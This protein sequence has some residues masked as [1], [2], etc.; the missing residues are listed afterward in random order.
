[1]ELVSPGDS[2]A[3]SA[4]TTTLA[5]AHELVGVDDLTVVTNSLPVAELLQAAG[6]Q[7]LTVVLTGGVRTP[8]DALVGPVAVAALRTLH[9]DWLFLGVHG[10]DDRAGLTTPNLLEAA[11]DQAL[12]SSAR[13]VVVVADSTK[14]GVVGLSSIAA[15]DEVDVLVTD[16]GLPADARRVLRQHVGRLL[17]PPGPNG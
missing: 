5:V 10:L 8:S 14:W 13:K 6:R 11:T 17:L 7:D 2:V 16:E 15:L 4:G 1:V 12:M 3:L 9:V